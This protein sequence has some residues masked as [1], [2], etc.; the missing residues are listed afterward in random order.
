MPGVVHEIVAEY[1]SDAWKAARGHLV[2]D[3]LAAQ[4]NPAIIKEIHDISCIGS[5]TIPHGTTRKGNRS[6]ADR[7][8]STSIKQTL[9]PVFILEVAYRQPLGSLYKKAQKWVQGTASVQWVLGVKVYPAAAPATP[10]AE[11]RLWQARDGRNGR[12]HIE[13]VQHKVRRSAGRYSCL[14]NLPLQ[15]I[16]P[17]DRRWPHLNLKLGQFLARNSTLPDRIQRRVLPIP[18]SPLP[19]KI[20][21]AAEVEAEEAEKEKARKRGGSAAPMKRKRQSSRYDLRR[22]PKKSKR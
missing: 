11:L 8:W 18:L 12:R 17:E 7:T 16:I 3:L 4:E 13:Q 14:A 9:C 10:R 21:V 20:I 1:I 15:T 19:E 5:P 2:T 22:E 6:Q